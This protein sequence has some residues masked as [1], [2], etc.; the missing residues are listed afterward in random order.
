MN[1]CVECREELTA[2]LGGSREHVDMADPAFGS[3]VPALRIGS[4]TLL[5]GGDKTHS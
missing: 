3:N 4:L 2:R 5:A 1:R